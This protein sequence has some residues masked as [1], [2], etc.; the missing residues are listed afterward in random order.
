MTLA[1]YAAGSAPEVYLEHLAVGD[2][3]AEMPLLLCWDRY[4]SVPLETTY[5]TAFRGRPVFWRA[6]DVPAVEAALTTELL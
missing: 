2:A 1:S 3:L 4:I 5:Q 6:V